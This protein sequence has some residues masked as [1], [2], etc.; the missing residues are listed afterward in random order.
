MN[1]ETI[2]DGV[3]ITLLNKDNYTLEDLKQKMINELYS[4][5]K[6]DDE[7]LIITEILKALLLAKGE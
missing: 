4:T 2:E 6:Y 7:E 3:K 5:T 1:V